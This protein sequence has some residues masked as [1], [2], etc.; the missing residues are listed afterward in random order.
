MELLGV[1]GGIASIAGLALQVGAGAMKRERT[2]TITIKNSSRVFT[3]VNPKVWMYSGRSKT[4]PAPTV[5]TET[6]EECDI[7]KKANTPAGAVGVLTYELHNKNMQRSNK[8]IAVMFSVPFDNN[9]FAN[10][11]AVGVF[12][13]TQLCDKKLFNLMYYEYS[14][15]F[16][17]AK[18]KESIRMHTNDPIKIRATMSDAG[19]AVVKLELLDTC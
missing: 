15:K 14:S 7:S 13:N 1:A 6:E 2:C 8:L 19:T 16:S 9:L 4:L 11:F 12:E 3:L 5:D 17:R 10:W 18:A